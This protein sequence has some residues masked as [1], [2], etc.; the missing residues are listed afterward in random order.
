MSDIPDAAPGD[1]AEVRA[2][3][4]DMCQDLDEI[5]AALAGTPGEA[6]LDALVR[7]VRDGSDADRAAALRAVDDALADTDEDAAYDDISY[8]EAPGLPYGPPPAGNRGFALP[9]WSSTPA[10]V[11][12]LC[13]TGGC[14]R[15]ERATHAHASPPACALTGLPLRWE[16][17]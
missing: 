3:I 11:V 7:A 6:A 4:A 15:H 17:L 12:F 8:R 13:P 9:P 10:S 5:R 16:R 14:S 2:G 1:P